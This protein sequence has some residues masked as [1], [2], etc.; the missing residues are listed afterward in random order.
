MWRAE[1]LAAELGSKIGGIKEGQPGG[2]GAKI[3]QQLLGRPLNFLTRMVGIKNVI[4][5]DRHEWL[6]YRFRESRC[7][8]GPTATAVGGRTL[9]RSR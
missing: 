6:C 5:L 8:A 2:R 7:L 1:Q 9:I 4:R 3:E